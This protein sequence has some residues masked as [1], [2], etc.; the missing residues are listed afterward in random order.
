MKTTEKIAPAA[1]DRWS[2]RLAMCTKCII[3]TNPNAIVL[4]KNVIKTIVDIGARDIPSCWVRGELC[5][6]ERIV[7]P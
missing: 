5:C 7:V 6:Y 3:A 1:T 4:P 2:V